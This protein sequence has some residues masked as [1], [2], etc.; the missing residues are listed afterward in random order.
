MAKYEWI[1]EREQ[2]SH[3]L[4]PEVISEDKDC[5]YQVVFVNSLYKGK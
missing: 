2:C 3:K 5:S 4:N 1:G